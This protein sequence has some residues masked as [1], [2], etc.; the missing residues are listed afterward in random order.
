MQRRVQV[1]SGQTTSLQLIPR[2]GRIRVLVRPWAQVTLDGRDLGVTPLPPIE[3]YE[4]NHTLMLENA[5]LKSRRQRS[6]TVQPGQ[7]LVIKVRMG[8]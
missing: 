8:R 7:E 2:K 1:K 3:V 4:G 5:S 6:L